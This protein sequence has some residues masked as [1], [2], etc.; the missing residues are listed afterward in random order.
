MSK[1]KVGAVILAAGESTRVGI[2]KQLLDWFGSPLIKAQINTLVNVGVDELLV[3]TGAY[4]DSVEQAISV[5]FVRNTQFNKG[6]STSVSIGVTALAKDT[7]T[8]M[9]LAVDQPRP[10]CIIRHLLKSHGETDK[11]ITLPKNKVGFGHPILFNKSLRIELT[12]VQEKTNGIRDIFFRYR[13]CINAVE[14]N[15]PIIRLDINTLSSYYNAIRQYPK[16]H[17]EWHEQQ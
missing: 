8:I 12:N 4:A 9:I 15:T 5:P 2:P 7:D 17:N 6:K 13:D 1:D 10:E 11:L 16:L 3:V 14:I